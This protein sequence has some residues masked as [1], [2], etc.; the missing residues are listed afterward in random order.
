MLSGGQR[1]RILLA[2]ALLTNPSLLILDEATSHL[3]TENEMLILDTLD[4]LRQER[5]ITTL[6][7]AHRL[8][9]VVRADRILVLHDGVVLA[10]GTHSEL[11]DSCATYKNLHKL[12]FAESPL[13]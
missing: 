8:S 4:E 7:V 10:C 9:T 13:E 3:D 5:S 1:Q 2:R 12:Q 6:V 11:L